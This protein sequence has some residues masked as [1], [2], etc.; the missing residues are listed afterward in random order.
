MKTRAL[1]CCFAAAALTFLSTGCY[2]NPHTSEK[3]PGEGPQNLHARPSVGPGSVSGGSTAGPQ[4]VAHKGSASEHTQPQPGG[5]T[6]HGAPEH[7]V[8]GAARPVTKA[9]NGAASDAHTSPATTGNEKGGD[10]RGPEAHA[11]PKH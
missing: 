2:N 5:A 4:P 1:T 10:R 11:E 7:G 3:R 8:Q 9:G 6:Q